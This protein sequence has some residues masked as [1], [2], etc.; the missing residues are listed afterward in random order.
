V[1]PIKLFRNLFDTQPKNDRAA[2]I[3]ISPKFSEEVSR[4]IEEEWIKSVPHY[5][6]DWSQE[7]IKSLRLYIKSCVLSGKRAE[8]LI[9][10]IQEN[11]KVNKETAEFLAL[12]ES[13]R[14]TV[15]LQQIRYQEA[16]VNEYRWVC[17]K[18]TTK[19]PVRPMHKK[20]NGE[21]FN[22]DNPP[23]VNEHGDRMHPGED[24]GCRC[25]AI[26]VVKFK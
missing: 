4:R 17:V 24:D 8:S 14:F 19:N 16:G 20:L 9:D 26:P 18:G 23:I 11:Y 25:C 3:T 13:K 1:N 12:Q 22:W 10:Y 2:E 7:G 21:I 6:R 15:K 5:L